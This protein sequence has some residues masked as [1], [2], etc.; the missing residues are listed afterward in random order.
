[1]QTTT[2]GNAG[3]HGAAP[4]AAGLPSPI[5]IVG[6]GRSG[7]SV[8][9]WA[10][11]Q[12]PNV[13][14]LPETHW[15]ARASIQMLQLHEFG[16]VNG[17]FSHLGALDWSDE[18]FFAAYGRAIDGLVASTREPRLR[19]IRKEAARKGGL[20]EAR[21][22]ELERAGQLSP[23]P[24]L[25]SARNYQVVR[26]PTEPKVRWV[27]GTPENTGYMYSLSLLFPGARF[28]HLLRDPVAVARSLMSFSRAGSAGKDH[29]E[30]EAFG[31]WLRLTEFAE[32]GERALGADRVL[33]VDFEDLTRS[34]E[35]TLRRCLRFVGEEFAPECLLP[36]NERINSSGARAGVPEPSAAGPAARRAIA[37]HDRLRSTPPGSPQAEAREALRRHVLEFARSVNVR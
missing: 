17:K 33:R 22:E 4:A 29:G 16:T 31:A 9:T 27:D 19:F 12:H 37:L 36:M 6:S 24:S 8:L 34:P 10:L 3:A 32:L 18:D 26:A 21:I 14:P 13:L 11:G 20:P 7:T 2:T 5:F 23:D 25:V 28:I 15:I 35:A 30:E 1:M